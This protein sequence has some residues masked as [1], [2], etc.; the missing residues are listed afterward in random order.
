MKVSN[1]FRLALISVIL[2]FVNFSSFAETLWKIKQ[3]SWH[4]T[5]EKRFSEFIQALGES[6]CDNTDKCLKNSANPYRNS[7]PVGIQFFSDCADFPYYLRAYFAWKN[8]LP[9]SFTSAVD[10]KDN[11]GDIRY[12]PSGNFVT[13]RFD[14]VTKNNSYPIGLNILKQL[15]G[16]I[17]SAMFRIP[18]EADSEKL[19]SDTYSASLTRDSLK[20]GTI[21]YDPAG[22]VA[23]VYRIESDGRILFMDAHP[24]NS[25]THGVYGKKFVRSRPS[26]GAGFKNWR[27]LQ[28]I[29]YTRDSYGNL[30]GG[31]VISKLNSEISDFSLIQYYGTHPDPNKKWN[32][33]TFVLNNET[34]D[35]YDYVRAV[36]SVGRLV[37]DPLVEVMNMMSGLCQDIQDR[38]TSVDLAIKNKIDMK[39]HP[40]RL[41][42]NIY[43]TDGEWESYSTPSRDARLK[44]SFRE[45]YTRTESFLEL[46]DSQ[47]DRLN[48]HG[49]NLKADLRAVYLNSAK[50]CNVNYSKSN[51]I[52]LTLSFQEIVNRLFKLSFDPYHCIELRWGASDPAELMSCKDSEGSLKRKWFLGEQYMRNQIDRTY[53]ARMDFDIEQ[54]FI[55]QKGNGV[56]EA[57]DVDLINLLN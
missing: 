35:Y 48:Y 57:P 14:V 1:Q 32:K 56:L 13:K 27:P 40:E 17:S 2:L 18:P 30:I 24:D 41:P 51:G 36:L 45:L 55:P 12:S 42:K 9:F 5:D 6:K 21:I 3:E 23:I 44:T 31:R 50:K 54:I 39:P 29:N 26:M 10:T 25:V 53:D 22:H 7:D 49:E 38:V 16:T 34:L 20:P 11:N 15:N 52:T 46:F 8:H 37:Y 19:F 43:G 47:P 28:L 33:G 4:E